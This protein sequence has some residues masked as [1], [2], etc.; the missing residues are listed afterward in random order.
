M[1]K[2]ASDPKFLRIIIAAAV[3][4]AVGLTLLTVM[5]GSNG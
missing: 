2:T 1:G 3:C 4:L 5:V